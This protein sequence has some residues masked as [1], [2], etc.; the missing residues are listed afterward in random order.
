MSTFYFFLPRYFYNLHQGF[1][2][3]TGSPGLPGKPGIKGSPGQDGDTGPMGDV[4]APG[5]TGSEGFPGVDG[6]V[7]A[8]GF[9]GRQGELGGSVSVS[10]IGSCFC[11]CCGCSFEMDCTD[12]T[13]RPCQNNL[14]SPPVCRKELRKTSKD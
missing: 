10:A 13:Y 8:R 4:G 14:A 6:G 7:G 11:Y 5:E 3:A 9:A 1:K 12:D 2:G